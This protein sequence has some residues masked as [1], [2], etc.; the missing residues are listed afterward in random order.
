MVHPS[1]ATQT[2]VCERVPAL[3]S[4]RLSA[5]WAL[6]MSGQSALLQH[7]RVWTRSVPKLYFAGLQRRTLHSASPAPPR[8]AR[9][10]KALRRP[11]VVAIMGHV[12][13]GKYALHHWSGAWWLDSNI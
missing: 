11:P 3:Q 4:R 2:R 7:C 5:L 6:C 9:H 12:D 8:P 1:A 10:L 13:H